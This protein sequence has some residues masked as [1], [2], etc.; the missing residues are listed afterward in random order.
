M[1]NI[2]DKVDTAL[3]LVI[4][5]SFTKDHSYKDTVKLIES[6]G[7][8]EKAKNAFLNCEIT[9]EEYICLCEKHEM[10]VDSYME[11]VEHNLVQLRLI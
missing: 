10:N 5:S 8:L 3:S 7:I 2:R 11:T 6:Y 4:P 9:F 1:N